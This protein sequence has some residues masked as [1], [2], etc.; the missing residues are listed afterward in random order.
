MI[1]VT[2]PEGA[3]S[4]E[5]RNALGERL[6][7]T[8]LK[9]EG[10]AEIPFSRQITAVYFDE[11]PAA[12]IYIAGVQET[13]PRY[14]VLVTIPEGSI[15][16]DERKAGLVEEVTRDV[17]EIDGSDDEAASLRVWVFIHEVPD[18]HWGGAGRIFRLRDIVKLARS[19]GEVVPA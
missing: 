1:D 15:K 8:I 14:R 18:G 11:R 3:L 6:T 9:W 16:D 19:G 4:E 13:Q 7:N 17:L 2:L 10:A 5:Q 12:S